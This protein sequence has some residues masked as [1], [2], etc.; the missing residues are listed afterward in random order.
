[1]KKNK[2]VG[3]ESL[4]RIIYSELSNDWYRHY[5][6]CVVKILL[7]KCAIRVLSIL[8]V[9]YL[10]QSENFLYFPLNVRVH[11]FH[12]MYYVSTLLMGISLSVY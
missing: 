10:N 12:L 3:F 1:M 7:G 8:A 6:C 2:N 4:Q 9:K 11:C 5:F